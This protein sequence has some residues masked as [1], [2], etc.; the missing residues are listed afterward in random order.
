MKCSTRMRRSVAAWSFSS[1]LTSPRQ[2]SD[3]SISVGRK[4]LRRER[5][6]ARPAGADEDDERQLGDRDLHGVA[7]DAL[8]SESCADDQRVELV[9][10]ALGALRQG[11][12]SRAS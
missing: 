11:R 3:D 6:L 8:D 4:C 9:A 1:S 10:R 12:C 2:K 5:G 7:A